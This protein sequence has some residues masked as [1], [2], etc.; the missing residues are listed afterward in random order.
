[1]R[2]LILLPLALAGLSGCVAYTEPYGYNQSYGYGEPAAVYTQPGHIYNAPPVYRY[3]AAPYG[4]SGHGY[5][6]GSPGGYGGHG[7]YGRAYRDRDRDRDGVPNRLDRDRDG[8]GV[9][10]R[11]DRRPNNPRLF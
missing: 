10:N 11:L 7:G 9:P 1:M 2:T 4:Y 8:D 5:Y 3:G 6:R